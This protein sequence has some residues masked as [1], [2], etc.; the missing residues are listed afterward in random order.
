MSSNVNYITRRSVPC[1][2][3]S[4]FI[5]ER[6]IS[7][8]V[9]H[10]GAVLEECPDKCGV[11]IPRCNAKAHRA[12]CSSRKSKK[13]SKSDEMQLPAPTDSVWKERVMSILNMMRTTIADGK[14]EQKELEARIA[15]S[16][17]TLRSKE[18]A[19]ETLRIRLSEASSEN[20][21]ANED[22]NFRI[23]RLEQSFTHIDEQTSL[24]FE[25]VYDQ[26][27]MLQSRLTD[28]EIE[29]KTAMKEWHAEL[30]GF[31]NFLSEE[32]VMISA[33]WHEQLKQIHDLKL[34]LEMRCKASKG[35]VKSH[36]ILAE[37]MD[38][39]VDEMRKHSEAIENQVAE[40]KALKFQMKEHINYVEDT[41]KEVMS[42]NSAQSMKC[43]C[44][45][46]EYFE[47]VPS[48]GR[49]LWR[50]DRYKEKMTDAKENDTLLCSPIFYNKEYGYTLRVELFLNGKGQWKERHI[51]GCL[52]VLE[53]KWDALLD[54]PCIL[55]ATVVL[56]DQENPANNVRKTLKVK[57]KD[58]GDD[59]NKLDKDSGMY[60]FIPHTKLTR[61]DG[62]TKN[63]VMF[64]DIQVKDF[65]IGG[66]MVSLLS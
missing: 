22:I 53:G 45:T 30:E 28:G 8:H 17:E 10:C 1:Y 15:Q 24:N 60:M 20:R 62:F 55:Q 49:L 42:Q 5:E 9:K 37:K 63:N 32:N 40:T 66:S 25:Q 59:S 56:R 27:N 26:L 35:L 12:Q 64:L 44:V 11:Y 51:I 21:Q 23:S 47:P 16:L 2:F 33:V 19:L 48:N 7:E 57:R 52:R 54:W 43:R 3:C 34:E 38:I 31:K 39:L 61:Y 46:E 58:A 18:A 14:Q 50:I 29:R 4:E 65:K 6:Y 13:M 41:M 36:D